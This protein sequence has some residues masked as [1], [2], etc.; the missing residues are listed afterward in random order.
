MVALRSQGNWRW[1]Q[2][3][4]Y[5]DIPRS[6]QIPTSP[7]HF[8]LA[9]SLCRTQAPGARRHEAG[10]ARKRKQTPFR[11]PALPGTGHPCRENISTRQRTQ[12]ERRKRGQCT[13]ASASVGAR[14]L[15]PLLPDS[16]W[17]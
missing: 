3:R 4:D 8:L 16:T 15:S 11:P 17:A 6:K 5:R 9:L 2:I 12:Q 14:R 1:D 7:M 10:R 13:P